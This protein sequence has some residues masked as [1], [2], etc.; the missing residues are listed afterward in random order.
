MSGLQ[1]G[2]SIVVCNKS[3][4]DEGKYDVTHNGVVLVIMYAEERVSTGMNL[5]MMSAVPFRAKP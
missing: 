4:V 5:F 2:D 3:P 1:L